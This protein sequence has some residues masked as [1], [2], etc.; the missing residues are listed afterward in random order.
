MVFKQKGNNDR[1]KL[2]SDKTN[3]KGKFDV[4]IGKAPLGNGKYYAKV[5]DKNTGSGGGD[6]FKDCL[7]QISPTV[8][9]S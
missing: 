1:K 8:K 3:D 6:D 2:G 5:N 7:A 4:K 9:I